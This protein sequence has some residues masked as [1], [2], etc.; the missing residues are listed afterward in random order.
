MGLR[1][2]EEEPLAGASDTKYKQQAAYLL[3]LRPLWGA[4]GQIKTP[5][6]AKPGADL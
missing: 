6:A 1:P 3:G 5:A 4:Y 2:H